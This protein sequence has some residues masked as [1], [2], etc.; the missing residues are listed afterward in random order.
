MQGD[1]YAT[2]LAREFKYRSILNYLSGLNNLLREHNSPVLD[3]NNYI[4]SS[5]LKGIRRVK[6][7]VMKQALPI[8]PCMLLSVF[9][10]LI[11]NPALLSW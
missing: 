3:Y 10:L 11:L 2:W 7:D 4:L 8:L 9:S 1:L 6:G 5:T